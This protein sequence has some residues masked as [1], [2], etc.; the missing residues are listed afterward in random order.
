MMIIE[1][2]DERERYTPPLTTAI[3]NNYVPVLRTSMG[4]VWSRK[5]H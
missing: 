1:N 4:D 2:V 5:G 3:R